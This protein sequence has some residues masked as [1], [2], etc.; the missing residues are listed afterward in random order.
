MLVL[1]YKRILSHTVYINKYVTNPLGNSY[2][3]QFDYLVKLNLLYLVRE[4]GRLG[5]SPR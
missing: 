3:R 5:E 2:G 4:H 1:Y